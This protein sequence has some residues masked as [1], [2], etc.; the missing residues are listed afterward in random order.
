M[1]FY[2]LDIFAVKILSTPIDLVITSP[3]TKILLEESERLWRWLDR[4]VSESGIVIIDLPG[5]YNQFTIL[6]WEAAERGV[7]WKLQWGYAL[8]SFYVEGDIQSLC[9]YSRQRA[10]VKYPKDLSY[11]KH[12]ER[13]MTHRCEWD[14][15]LI[16]YL[17]EQYSE[18][19]QVVLDP[20]CGTATVPRVAEAL[21]RVGIGIDRREND[22]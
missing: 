19:A 6:T 4:M 18:P 8:Y 13:E 16:T 21:G 17:I 20:F 3:S 10:S 15:T 2:D 14:E 12:S 5:Q 22:L 7:G 1:N 11:R 9:C